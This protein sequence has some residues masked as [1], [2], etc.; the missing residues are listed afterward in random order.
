MKKENLV[1]MMILCTLATGCAQKAV[2]KPQPEKEIVPAIDLS[3]MDTTINPAE[4]FFRYA[5]NNW[6]KNNP[7]PEEYST[8]GAFTEID[9]HNE[10]LIQ[11]IIDEVS[12]DAN[13][14][15]GSLA[16][17]ISQQRLRKRLR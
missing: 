17:K 14:T 12:K 1:A 15:Q 3:N 11:D 4:D 16:Q 8:Y 13:A 2:E 10:I 5:N 7:I 9:Q 6:I